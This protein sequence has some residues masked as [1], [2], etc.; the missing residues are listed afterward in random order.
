MWWEE[1]GDGQSSVRG[2]RHVGQACCALEGQTK[3]GRWAA[4]DA[5]RP[6]DR[7]GGDLGD[8]SRALLES[9]LPHLAWS[10]QDGNAG[11]AIAGDGLI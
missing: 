6:K 2:R 9:P 11:A 3:L 1:L 5:G 10:P 7:A 8:R 4:L